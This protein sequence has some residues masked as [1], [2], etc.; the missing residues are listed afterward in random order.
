MCVL[1]HPC[2]CFLMC[3][4]FYC[5]FI[6]LHVYAFAINS[7][8]HCGSAFEPGASGIPYYCTSICVRSCCTWHASCMDSKPKKKN[9]NY[10][11]PTTSWTL[12]HTWIP[13]SDCNLSYGPRSAWPCLP[14]AFK[15]KL[16][17]PLSKEKLY[18]KHLESRC[19]DQWQKHL[20]LT[21]N[22]PP[23]WVRG[24]CITRTLASA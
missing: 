22:N 1:I 13:H 12:G 11:S 9:G 21:L 10:G 2:P 18:K 24:I 6:R 14:F 17:L 7:M 23:G 16:G 5:T 8:V 19:S 20:E 15:H 4:P 3:I